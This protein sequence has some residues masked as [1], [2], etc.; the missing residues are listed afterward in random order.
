MKKMTWSELNDYMFKY[1]EDNGYVN[2]G[3]CPTEKKI[4]A[5]VVF[6]QENYNSPYT[7]TERSYKFSNDEKH[8]YPGMNSN[9]IWADCLDGKDLGVKI[10][11]Y[12][13]KVE[14]CYLLEQ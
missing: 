8:F 9:S 7:E 14:Y 3:S 11:D 12:N 10:T 5:V 2:K 4:W 1:N 6:K 13:W